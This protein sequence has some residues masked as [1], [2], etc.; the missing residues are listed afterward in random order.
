[1]LLPLGAS[2]PVSD[3]PALK[4]AALKVGAGVCTAVTHIAADDLPDGE[5]VSALCGGAG[6]ASNNN[7]KSNAMDDGDDE[8]DEPAPAA[9]AGG[10]TKSNLADVKTAKLWS[11]I[12]VCTTL[13]TSHHTSHITHPPT[14]DV[15]H[16][17]HTFTVD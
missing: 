8:G 14:K 2:T 6:A 10:D 17:V 11:N 9:A 15:S 12:Y 1:M 13:T 7:N 5:A 4:F 3:V 16:A